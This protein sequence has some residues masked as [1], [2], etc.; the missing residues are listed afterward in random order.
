MVLTR[1]QKV[2]VLHILEN[3]MQLPQ[4]SSMALA[5]IQ[6]D[7]ISVQDVLGM[8]PAFIESLK[9]VSEAGKDPLPLTAGH[10]GL[11]SA[12]Q[13]CNL[14]CNNNNN[15]IIDTDWLHLMA[16]EFDT[17]CVNNDF[18]LFKMKG[19]LLQNMSNYID[20]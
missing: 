14:F 9:Y 6:E 20:C 5:L 11:L 13:S 1:A 12:F 7:L 16:E 18:K 19:G 15:P 4:D 2:S 17:Y 8:S 10:C 3:V